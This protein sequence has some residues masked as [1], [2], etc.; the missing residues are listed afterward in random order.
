M[1]T[2]TEENELNLTQMWEQAQIR[3]EQ[4]TKKSLKRTKIRN[5]DE[6]I[7]LLNQ[8]LEA[9]DSE[10]NSKWHQVK[11]SV[12][13][14]LKFIE[15]LGGIAAQGASMVFG[16]ATMCFNAIQFLMDI[17]AK[18]SK[19]Y[20]DIGQLFEE[21]SNFRMQFKIFHRMEQFTKIDLSL[22]K[23][24]HQIMI[25]FVDICAISIDYLNPSKLKQ[26]FNATKIAL[27][28]DDSGIHV[29][30]EEF[31]RLIEYQSRISD[32]LT[33]ESALKSETGIEQL[34][35]SSKIS[36]QLIEENSE[37]LRAT[38]DDVKDVKEV[39]TKEAKERS[40]I[41]EHAEQIK[42]IHDKLD[43][44]L[45]RDL[46]PEREFK[47]I[48]P[49]RLPD[50][51]EWLKEIDQY[52]HWIDLDSN[53]HVLLFL[54]GS[55]GSGKSNLLS[56]M[57]D[58]QRNMYSNREAG[59]KRVVISCFGF[60]RKDKSAREGKNARQSIH[61]LKLMATQIASQD[62]V[63]AKFLAMHLKNKGI[64]FS[65]EMTANDLI[66][67]L[68]LPP[69]MDSKPDMA[70]MLLLDG[71]DQLVP[72][73]ASQLINALRSLK[74][75]NFRVAVT[76]TNTNP[77]SLKVSQEELDL[78]PTIRVEDHNES[79]IK[80][81]IENKL[82]AYEDLNSEDPSILRIA[83]HVRDKL[84][85][86]ASGN[87]D[88]VQQIIAKVQK[89]VSNDEDIA[90]IQGLVSKD[91]LE[92]KELAAERIVE[93]LNESLNPQEIEQL[94]ELLIWTVYGCE[95]M[96]VDEMRAA[97][98]LRTKRVP[99]QK[100]ENKIREKYAKIVKTRPEDDQDV[101]Y[102]RNDEIAEFLQ[103]TQRSNKGRES[104]VGSDPKISMT[105]RFENVRLSQ[106]RRFVWKL[107]EKMTFDGLDFNAPNIEEEARTMIDANPADA[108]LTLTR[109]CLAILLD[110]QK[111]DAL[112]RYA[113]LYLPNHLQELREQVDIS[114][115]EKIEIVD[116]LISVLQSPD[117]IDRDLSDEYLK[118]RAWHNVEVFH[119]WLT[120]SEATKTLKRRDRDW[121]SSVVSGNRMLILEN[122]ATMIARHWLCRTTWSPEDV[123]E[124]INEFL[125]RAQADQ[126]RPQGPEIGQSGEAT[127]NSAENFRGVETEDA[128]SDSSRKSSGEKESLNP[129]ERIQRA[130]EW[131][132]Q[133]ADITGKNSL[134]YER[135]GGTYLSAGIYDLSKE[136]FLEAKSLPNPSW[137]T[138]EGLAKAHS[139]SDKDKV[140]A[141][142]EMEIALATLGAKQELTKDERASLVVNLRMA[143]A[144]QCDLGNNADA[145]HKLREAI[146]FDSRTYQSHDMLLRLYVRTERQPEALDFL[147]H[148]GNQPA[149]NEEGLTDLG[150]MFLE[151][152]SWYR[153]LS[154]FRA[155][156]QAV[157]DDH[158][159]ATIL[160]TL[161][162][163]LQVLKKQKAD[164]EIVKLLLCHGVALARYGTTEKGLETAVS[165][166]TKCY[167]LGIKSADL[168]AAESG[169]RAVDFIFNYHFTNARATLDATD[170]LQIHSAKLE[171]LMNDIDALSKDNNPV[172]LLNVDGLRFAHGS[173][174]RLAGDKEKAKMLLLDQMKSGLD[175]LSDDD[176]EN[177]SWGY[178][179]VAN[180]L[181]HAG[182][183]L[184]ALSAW[185]LRGPSERYTKGGEAMRDGSASE[186]QEQF[187]N[188][189]NHS[190]GLLATEHAEAEYLGLSCDG[191]CGI[192]L[193]WSD[194]LWF[195]KV[196]EDVQFEDSCFT[197][198]KKGTLQRFVCSADHDFLRVPSW[199]DEFRATG[200]DHVRVG[201]EFIDGQRVGG[202][203]VH[204]NTWLDS[205]RKQWSIEKPAKEISENAGPEAF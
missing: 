128:E 35:E 113:I 101:I 162:N 175:L 152:S 176:P 90:A 44:A 142:Q 98:L 198:L 158:W 156:F 57:I 125:D 140:L 123:Y 150:S 168:S 63:Y 103:R 54:S 28:D 45:D 135:V 187:V 188:T 185:S 64:S 117:R 127:K 61:A 182:D 26:F 169:R 65:Q 32:G 97:L 69:K 8:K 3:F 18:I 17:P 100:L 148:L 29:K 94:N 116:D 104:D 58:E 42:R 108:Y 83:N 124:W 47:Q 36:R 79:D 110:N 24:T 130:L 40:S 53:A 12:T 27:F 88:N 161:E 1:A 203:V 199:R 87:F 178:S 114:L 139:K 68:F 166:W 30:L 174:Y 78:I 189:G 163:T 15:L 197:K 115:E 11:A 72:E 132:E 144:W 159:S 84:P 34:K 126:T 195:C 192:R 186:S 48:R 77:E 138:F 10:T 70:Y 118:S 33:L 2:S 160:E 107:N 105:I 76:V 133:K 179:H 66:Q 147:K 155:I 200:K 95:Y 23:C 141:L 183:D 145:I 80:R 55:N 82:N 191:Q 119:A 51:G 167:K 157:Q 92:N 50:T 91:Q 111:N 170:D 171:D 13:N 109:R 74:A 102:M 6:A 85:R 154:F 99:L 4:K 16:P 205:I 75:S 67:E 122:I 165:Q 86:V 190:H 196:C 89:A 60:E 143:A 204:V 62:I 164:D 31:R 106:A 5:L 9:Q 136:S 22:R 25:A 129:T 180:V 56:A 149:S 134:W 52:R 131:A 184:N 121:L 194:S 81:Y 14:V 93:E 120:D 19:F 21:I 112:G 177:D 172:T 37:E 73:E 38:H 46:D 173:F 181:A 96:S 201:G 39:V 20:D 7:E 49:D 41:N 59:S 153:P 146:K 202:E 43:I 151:Y 71:L 137:R 193:T